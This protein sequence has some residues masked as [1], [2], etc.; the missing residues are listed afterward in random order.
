[1]DVGQELVKGQ[2]QDFRSQG[3]SCLDVLQL[4]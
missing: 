3:R 1:M 2:V 4:S